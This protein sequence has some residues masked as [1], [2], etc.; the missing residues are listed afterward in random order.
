MTRFPTFHRGSSEFDNFDPPDPP[1]E[2]PTPEERE[3]AFGRRV[4]AAYERY[5]D[6]LLDGQ[7][8][9]AGQGTGADVQGEQTMK[10]RKKPVVIEA[11]QMTRERRSDNRDWPAWLNMAWNMPDNSVGALFIDSNDPECERLVIGTL[12]GVL[13]VDWGDW[14]IQGVKKE[15]YACKPDIFAATY[16]P[17]EE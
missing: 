13:R 5:V 14:I 6:R 11:F 9:G 4:D 3:E 10:F 1:D 16:E 7:D 2:A 17:V 8:K 12:E 15:I